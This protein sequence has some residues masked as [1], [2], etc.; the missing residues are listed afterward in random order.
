M[1][2]EVNPFVVPH[3]MRSDR[4]CGSSGSR[5]RG[6]KIEQLITRFNNLESTNQPSSCTVTRNLTGCGIPRTSQSLRHRRQ[7]CEV[8]SADQ[9]NGGAQDMRVQ[10]F[11][12]GLNGELKKTRARKVNV[13]QLVGN[14]ASYIS[15]SKPLLIGPPTQNS[16]TSSNRRATPKP[17][18]TFADAR[19]TPPSVPPTNSTRTNVDVN[20][21]ITS[22]IIRRDS[23]RNHWRSQSGGVTGFLA[24]RRSAL[25]DRL[26]NEIRACKGRPSLVK[27]RQVAER[28]I[29]FFGVVGFGYSF[30]GVCL[31][32][33]F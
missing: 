33:N 20:P 6:N 24:N 4:T 9:P 27:V 11:F 21:N 23:S 3:W 1:R 22:R 32:C 31:F 10:Q 16:F 29:G 28:E 17:R 2:E 26:A 18:V 8:N 19:N 15:S 7:T 5:R 12:A 30:R 14:T 25:M 13:G